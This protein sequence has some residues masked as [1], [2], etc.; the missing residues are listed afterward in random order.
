MLCPFS[1]G[2]YSCIHGV[3]IEEKKKSPDFNLTGSQSNM[4]KLLRSAKNISGLSNMNSARI[5]SPKRAADLIN[6]WKC[7]YF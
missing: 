1:Q 6:T 2:I 5:D 7:F 3:H 4:L